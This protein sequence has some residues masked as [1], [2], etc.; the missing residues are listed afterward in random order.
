[1]HFISPFK[2]TNLEVT[3]CISLNEFHHG[4][5]HR[6]LL[7]VLTNV[8]LVSILASVYRHQLEFFKLQLIKMKFHHWQVAG[9][10]IPFHHWQAPQKQFCSSATKYPK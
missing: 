7:N 9:F 6:R 4:N 8:D 1:M 2:Y 3:G 5:I 10:S